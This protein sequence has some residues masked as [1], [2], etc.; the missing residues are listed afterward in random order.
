LEVQ[1]W[2]EGDDPL[3]LHLSLSPSCAWAII[4][5][6]SW[7]LEPV[8]DDEEEEEGSGI[9]PVERWSEKFGENGE[10]H[11]RGERVGNARVESYKLGW[12]HEGVEGIPSSKDVR[13]IFL[14]HSTLAG[15]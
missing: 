15:Y 9:Y 2:E 12:I 6:T 8:S 4:K 14:S 5:D 7:E 10:G 13:P 3:A 1:E 11:P